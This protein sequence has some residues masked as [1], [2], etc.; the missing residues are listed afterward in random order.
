MKRRFRSHGGTCSDQVGVS[1]TKSPFLRRLFEAIDTLSVRES[2][3]VLTGTSAA[4]FVGWMRTTLPP[5]ESRVLTD[6]DLRAVH[7]VMCTWLELKAGQAFGSF[8]TVA[9]VGHA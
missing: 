1:L 2:G 6:A 8:E 5:E 4:A 3:Y 7:D 9:P